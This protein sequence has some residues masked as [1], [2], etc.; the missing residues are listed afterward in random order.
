MTRATEFLMT[1]MF[2]MTPMFVLPSGGSS[3]AAPSPGDRIRIRQLDGPV[4]TGTLAAWSAETIRL[5]ADSG[6]VEV[7]V[8]RIDVLETSLGQ[9]RSGKYVGL[10]LL[11]GAIVG[12][13]YGMTRELCS[14]SF[15]FFE[16]KTRDTSIVIGLIGGSLII[17]LPL[18]IIL[19]SMN[20]EE[21]WTRVALR[22][23]KLERRQR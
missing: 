6:Q 23:I 3:Q 16:P 7:P 14:G 12:A 17:G 15:C 5:S 19:G 20:S 8:E 4:L 1:L 22:G 2:V 11:G 10:S 21:R 18:G 13:A 9:Q